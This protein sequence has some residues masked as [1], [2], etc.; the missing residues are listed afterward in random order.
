MKDGTILVVD[1][2]LDAL[3]LLDEALT[4]E[5]YRVHR[6]SSGPEAVVLLGQHAFDLIILDIMLPDM[7]GFAILDVIRSSE[8]SARIPVIFQTAYP[9]QEH[10]RR[11]VDAGETYMLCKP[12]DIPLFVKVVDRC[13][14]E[15]KHAKV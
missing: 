13:L 11:I 7:N 10:G 12:L 5:G 8:S 2:N 4:E 1:D 14:R 9:S 6:A 15:S 3:D